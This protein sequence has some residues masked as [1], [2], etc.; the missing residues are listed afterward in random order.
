[1]TFLGHHA[2][3]LNFMLLLL[4]SSF[5]AP[6]FM[7]HFSGVRF[8]AKKK[9]VRNVLPF[10]ICQKLVRRILLLKFLKDEIEG[11]SL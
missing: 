7:L 4:G 10:V 9:R 6:V 2:N 5:Y 1:M 8:C 11:S 3:F